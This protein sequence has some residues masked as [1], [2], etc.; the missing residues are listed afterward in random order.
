M[1]RAVILTAL[2]TLSPLPAPA[3]SGTS[4]VTDESGNAAIG[5]ALS[6]AFSGTSGGAMSI[7]DPL[8]PGVV[9]TP[10]RGPTEMPDLPV[11]ELCAQASEGAESFAL[12]YEG[13]MTIETAA[14]DLI[15]AD[16]D[17]Y[18]AYLFRACTDAARLRD[19]SYVA[20]LDCLGSPT[21]D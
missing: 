21:Q 6:G 3:Q 18:G 13:C 4:S 5:G 1:L 17:G 11:Q 8:S 15:E 7:S 19:G 2:I 14:Y 16:L 20:L 12:A 9:G 10:V